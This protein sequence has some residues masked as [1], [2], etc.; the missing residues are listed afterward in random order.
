MTPSRPPNSNTRAAREHTSDGATPGVEQGLEEFARVVAGRG[1]LSQPALAALIRLHMEA[2]LRGGGQCLAENYLE[3]F[4][5]VAGDPELAVDVIYSEFLAREEAGQQPSLEEYRA[6]FPEHAQVLTEQIGLHQALGATDGQEDRDA[7]NDR[8]E[9][10]YEVLEQIGSG[11]MGVVF[12]ARQPALNRMVA[13]KMVRAVDATNQELLARFRSEA[14]MVAA[15]HH[16]RIVQVYDYGEYEGLP[17]LAME[18]VEGGSLADRLNGAVWPPRLAAET[19]IDLADAVQFAHE[20]QIVHRDLKP[21]NILIAAGPKDLQVKVTDFGLAKFLFDDSSL[22]TRSNTFLGTPAYMAPELAHGHARDAGPA[23][24]VYSLGAILY[25]ML[26]GRPPYSGE[27]SL[28]TLRRLLSEEI[29]PL[30]RRARGVP[31]DLAT[32]CHKCLRREPHQRYASA[33]ALKA[34]LERFLA[35]RPIEARRIGPIGR[36]WRWCRRNPALTTAF[37]S[38]VGLLA[39]IAALSL[40]FS[41]QISREL[42]NTT[43]AEEEA[44][45]AHLASE[46]RLWDAYLAEAAA[47]NG[48]HKIGQRYAALDTIDQAATLMKS[49]GETEE[50]RNQLRNAVLASVALT[51][52]RVHHAL[53]SPIIASAPCAMSAKRDCYFAHNPD[54]VLQGFQLSSGKRQWPDVTVGPPGALQLTDDGKLL[55]AT[56]EPVAS[57]WRVE[58]HELRKLWEV[59][60]ARNFFLSQ[61]GQLAVYLDSQQRV[62]LVRGGDGSP[63][64]RL[65]S[66][67]SLWRGAFH[68]SQPQVALQYVDRVKIFSTESGEQISELP[69]E[70][71]PASMLTWHPDGVHL[72][73][74]SHKTGIELWNVPRKTKEIVYPHLG[75]AALLRFNGDGTLL[76]SQSLWNERVL[77]WDVGTGLRVLEMPAY[78]LRAC[79]EGHDGQLRLLT[80]QRNGP[81]VSDLTPGKSRM[82]AQ[83][84]EPPVGYTSRI[85]VSP[86][87]RLVAI[88]SDKGWELWDAQSTRR[89]YASPL[90]MCRVAFSDDGDLWVSCEQGL[91]RLRRSVIEPSGGPATDTALRV[92]FGPPE[93]L[94]EDFIPNLFF[95]N[96]SG[97]LWIE[98]THDTW[99]VVRAGSGAAELADTVPDLRMGDVSDDDRFLAIAGWDLGK[100]RVWSSQSAQLVANL[101][102]GPHGVVAFSRDSKLLA[103]TPDG[104][105]V[106]R[107]S[108]WQQ[109]AQLHAEGTTPTGLSMAFSPDS[110]VLAV[111]QVDGLLGLFDPYSGKKWCTL[112]NLDFSWART[113]A[114][115]RDQRVLVTANDER[116]PARVWDLQ[117]MQ[118]ELQARGLGFPPGV[119]EVQS[120]SDGRHLPLMI[121]IEEG[122]LTPAAAGQ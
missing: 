78:N 93:R 71:Y 109:I 98:R 87:S 83:K 91:F 20:Q 68:P 33:G 92:H 111:G 84:L 94:S 41:A 60:D 67:P 88:S 51:D 63:L 115:G 90:G 105:T 7:M 104:V 85:S 13:L 81:V 23:C 54:G 58:D 4:P 14:Q 112:G 103:A 53:E 38:V 106:W 86:D 74:W 2:Q 101:P 110:R 3:R 57:L 17:Y 95:M 15:L 56:N 72:A 120:P 8:L 75:L 6:R 102:I 73:V 114:F 119:L 12:K 76:V 25:E 35:G 62:Q 47:S 39:S 97:T 49:L 24:D 42:A 29:E 82:L 107:T 96:N 44:R 43:K 66:Q 11:G 27:S 70:D 50:R 79:S 22:K 77:I 59:A 80:N 19:L 30:Q 9:A 99:H 36:S 31:R 37:G 89:R 46:R 5:S 113:M 122:Q 40:M 10:N 48:S 18:L 118:T 61:D 55:A 16:P 121:E 45:S 64:R 116:S 52:L 28:S 69:A 108:D 21:A 32:I 117:G 34:D 65:G 1:E 100:A 26:G